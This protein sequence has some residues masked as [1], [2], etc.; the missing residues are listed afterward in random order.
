MAELEDLAIKVNIPD[1]V[2]LMKQTVPEFVSKNS[3]YEQYDIV[4]EESKEESKG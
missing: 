2:R 1:M 4:H 3:E